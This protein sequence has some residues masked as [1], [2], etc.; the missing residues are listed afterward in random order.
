MRLSGH[1]SFYGRRLSFSY[2]RDMIFVVV[3]PCYP[4]SAHRPLHRQRCHSLI[5]FSDVFERNLRTRQSFADRGHGLTRLID[6]MRFLA[7]EIMGR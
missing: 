7:A 6:G 2:L 3:D 5:Q 1:R 4:C